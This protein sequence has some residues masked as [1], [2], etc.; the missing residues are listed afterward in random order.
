MENKK[1][2]I[3]KERVSFLLANA[4]EFQL[5]EQIDRIYF[6]NPFSVEILRK[7]DGKDHGIIL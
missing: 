3:S 5:P 4:E 6:F 2:A 7:S 1:E